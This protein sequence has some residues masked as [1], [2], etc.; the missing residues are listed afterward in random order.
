M[1]MAADTSCNPPNGIFHI[2]MPK[3]AAFGR[4]LPNAA[5]LNSKIKDF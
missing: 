5:S 4:I 1:R 2:K 3:L